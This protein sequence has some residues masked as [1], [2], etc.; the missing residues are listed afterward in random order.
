MK[1]GQIKHRLTI[2]LDVQYLN[3]VFWCSSAVGELMKTPGAKRVV[4]KRPC[5]SAPG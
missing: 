5:G 4:N 3:V 1:S 2:V